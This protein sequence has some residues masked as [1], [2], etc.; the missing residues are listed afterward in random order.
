MFSIALFIS[1]WHKYTLYFQDTDRHI[2]PSQLDILT[3]Y[4]Q[5]IYTVIAVHKLCLQ[6][7]LHYSNSYINLYPIYNYIYSSTYII[8]TL[9]SHYI[10]TMFVTVLTDTFTLYF[11]LHLH[12]MYRTFRA[13]FTFNLQLHYFHYTYTTFATISQLH[14][15]YTYN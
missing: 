1:E 3:L 14:L 11:Q 10:Y 12:Y 5:Y 4:L 8:F 7:R 9:P 2:L 15:Y 6:L 13:I